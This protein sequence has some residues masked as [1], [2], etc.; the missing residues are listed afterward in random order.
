MDHST[1]NLQHQGLESSRLPW[2]KLPSSCFCT[3]Q[4]GL[5]G[6][7]IFRESLFQGCFEFCEEDN[8]LVV[9]IADQ[10]ID[11]PSSLSSSEFKVKQYLKNA[12]TCV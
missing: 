6:A 3:L 7:K 9:G 1:T 12:G 2:Q 8:S 5:T 11:H 4:E 10:R